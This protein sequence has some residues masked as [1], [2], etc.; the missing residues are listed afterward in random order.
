M[1]LRADVTILALRPSWL[2]GQGLRRQL[3]A[4]SVVAGLLDWHELAIPEAA[5]PLIQVNRRSS[6]VI[7]FCERCGAPLSNLLTNAVTFTPPN[8]R[9]EVRLDANG[10]ARIRVVDNGQGSIRH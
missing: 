10:M 3:G 2:G 6:S 4:D 9:I 7:P 8:E 5:S 1:P